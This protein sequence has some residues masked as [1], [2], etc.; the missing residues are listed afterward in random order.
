[1]TKWRNRLGKDGV[2]KLL[3]ETINTGLKSKTIK[4]NSLTKVTV[5]TTVQEKN[6][7][8]PTDSKLLNKARELWLKLPN[9]TR[10]NS[11]KI[12]TAN[13]KLMPLWQD[14]THM[15]NSLKE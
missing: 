4:P 13:A 1:M 10:S 7:A 2:E 15:Q 14:A 3:I 9:N 8:F 12:T 6:I 11:D 5:D